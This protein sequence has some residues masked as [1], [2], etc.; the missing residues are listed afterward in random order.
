MMMVED[1]NLVRCAFSA[2]N[3]VFRQDSHRL[4]LKKDIRNAVE[5]CV[6]AGAKV[7]IR[8]SFSIDFE[9]DF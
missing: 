3:F 8:K 9:Q 7:R 1:M 6:E 2:S 4:R 5:Q